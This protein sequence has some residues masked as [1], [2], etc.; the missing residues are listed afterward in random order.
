MI[1]TYSQNL[2]KWIQECPLIITYQFQLVRLSPK[3]G[4]IEGRAFFIDQSWLS[5]FEFLSLDEQ[6]VNREKYRY[7]YM[8]KD[9]K[10]IFRY[11]NAPHHPGIKTFPNHKHVE[12]KV[13][14]SC[15]PNINDILLETGNIIL[16][17]PY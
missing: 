7:Q 1:N 14:D 9:N 4:Y 6:K 11:D 15:S 3:T 2:E 16:N 8:T 10:M 5:F 17:L 12:N 13:L